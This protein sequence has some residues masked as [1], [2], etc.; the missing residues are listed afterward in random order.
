M[1]TPAALAE[2]MPSRHIEQPKTI[3]PQP[4]LEANRRPCIEGDS[5]GTRFWAACDYKTNDG[6]KRNA[7]R[8]PSD[9]R[10]DHEQ[11]QIILI[12]AIRRRLEEV[13]EGQGCANR[14]DTAGKQVGKPLLWTSGQ[15]ERQPQQDSDNRCNKQQDDVRQQ[16]RT[17]DEHETAY[18][19]IAQP[20]SSGHVGHNEVE[21]PR[22]FTFITIFSV[23]DHYIPLVGSRQAPCDAVLRSMSPA[24]PP[25]P[26]DNTGL[27]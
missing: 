7:H 14:A 13:N 3:M 16:W 18:H 2:G 1:P 26:T 27:P 20:L 10:A 25:G 9:H 15:P 21:S 19:W 4:M 24:G 11:G 6:A 17:G 23:W 12:R 22:A 8:C 5:V